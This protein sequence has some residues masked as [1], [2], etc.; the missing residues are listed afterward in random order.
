MSI[1]LLPIINIEATQKNNINITCDKK[2]EKYINKNIKQLRKTIPNCINKNKNK[3]I[4]KISKISNN[5]KPNIY[6][7]EILIKKFNLK[8]YQNNNKQTSTG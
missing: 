2:T 6:T 8:L 1:L 5:K 3:K 4:N 7:N